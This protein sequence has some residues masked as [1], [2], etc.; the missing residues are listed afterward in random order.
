MANG[1]DP[2]GTESDEEQVDSDEQREQPPR[3]PT[4]SQ[5]FQYIDGYAHFIAEQRQRPLLYVFYPSMGMVQANHSVRLYDMFLEEGTVEDLDVILHSTGA[6]LHEAYDMIKLCRNYTDGEVTVFVPM[7]AMSAAT[8]IAIGADQVVLSEIG[9]LGPLDPQVPHPE[10]HR[11]MPVRSVTEI[12]EVLEKGLASSGTDVPVEVKGK[13]I[14]KPIAEQVD[15]YFLTEHEKTA[16]L[17]REYG[18]KLLSQRGYDESHAER[19]LDYLI[20]YPTHSYSVDLPEIQST[21]DLSQVINA[22]NIKSLENG[23]E[24]ES[25]LIMMLNFFLHYDQKYLMKGEPRAEPRI[26]LCRPLP[27]EQ[28]QQALSEVHQEEEHDQQN[29]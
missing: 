14:I 15:P 11:Y 10:G 20:E 4:D 24:L 5:I 26:E 6:D 27:E 9:K 2:N 13:A 29:E 17:A 12:P 23:S 25:N 8:L 21:P 16:D 7:Q 1:E 22:V 19:C 18:Q 28:M 3:D